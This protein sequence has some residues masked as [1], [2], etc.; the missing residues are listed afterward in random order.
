MRKQDLVYRG[1][2][3]T[4]AALVFGALS[5]CGSAAPTPQPP[6]SAQSS[7]PQ[8]IGGGA[9]VK[10]VVKRQMGVAMAN[11][12]GPRSTLAFVLFRNQEANVTAEYVASVFKQLFKKDVKVDTVPGPKSVNGFLIQGGSLTFVI[13]QSKIP[14]VAPDGLAAFADQFSEEK[15]RS[16]VAS[17]TGFVTVDAIGVMPE[18]LREVMPFLGGLASFFVD[19]GT[20]A[21]FSTFFRSAIPATPT[22]IDDLRTG[23]IIG[24][25]AFAAEADQARYGQQQ[26]A[27]FGR[28]I[29]EAKRTFPEFCARWNS[30]SPESMFMVKSR[31]QEG[32]FVEHMWS[33]VDSIDNGVVTATLS[34]RPHNLVKIQEG[35]KHRITVEQLS[36]WCY[37]DNRE[38]AGAFTDPALRQTLMSD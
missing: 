11:F 25:L 31:F 3:G 2:A 30:R 9:N 5:G 38:S 18:Q 14:Y 20:T 10:D 6:Q 23:Y 28:G 29:E 22:T 26:Q 19:E 32:E 17:H 15:T 37:V 1:C 8:D 7:A 34:N 27:E 33:N 24:L 12:G 4:G 16:L 13:T 35:Q 21:V 36:D